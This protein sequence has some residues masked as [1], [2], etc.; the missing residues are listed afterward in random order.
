MNAKTET[1]VASGNQFHSKNTLELLAHL[2]EQTSDVLTAADINFKPLTWNKA[3][4]K[5][6]GLTSE[7]VIGSDVRNFLVINYSGT[8]RDEVRRIINTTGEWRGEANFVRPTDNKLITLLIAFKQLKEDGEV[9]GYL[10]C[11]TD[12]TERKKAEQRL[13]ESE[14]RFRNMADSSPAMIWLS[15]ESNHTIYTNQKW[16]EFTGQQI[17]NNKEGWRDFVHKDDLAKA[18][19]VFDEAFNQK[20]EVAIVYRLRRFDGTYRWVHDTSVPRFLSDG[21]FIGYIGSV[22]DIEDE[23]QKQEQLVYQATI[24]ENVSDIIFT[25]DLNNIIRTWNGPAEEHY[26]ICAKDAIAKRVR[27][28]LSFTFYD[29][30]QEEAYQHLLNKGI[31]KGEISFAKKNGDVLY[32]NHTVKYIYN[33]E[34][35]KIGFLAVGQDITKKKLAEEQMKE[36][37][38]FY[39]TLIADSLDGM[40]LTN[41][42]GKITFCSPS[43]KNVLG[44]Q[45]DEIVGKNAFEFVHP[46]DATYA[47]TS[48]QREVKEN[49]EVKYITVRLLKNT[50][51]WIWCM[52][53][54][55]NLLE[56]SYINSIVIYFHDDSLRKRAQDALK[57][58]E[59]RFRSLVRDLQIGVFLSDGNGNIIMC[60]Q[61]LSSMLSIPEEWVVGKNVYDIISDDVINEKNE[62]IPLEERPLTQ[63]LHLKKTIKDVVIGLLHPITKE[64]CWILVNSNP[65]LDEE[66]NLKHVVCS[67]MN[68]TERKKLEQKLITDQISHQRQLTQ[69]TI[70]GQEKERTE[71]GKELHDN[72]GQQLTSI[73]LF[74]DLAKNTADEAT[75]EMVIMAIKGVSDAINEVRAMSRS[76]VPHTL[77]DLGLIESINE[78]I[79]SFSRTQLLTIEMND[80]EFDEGVLP[81]NQKLTLFRIVQEQLNNI[82]KHAQADHVQIKLFSTSDGILLEIKDDGNGFDIEKVRKGLGFINIKNRAELFNGNAEIFSKPGKGCLL[83]VFFP[84]PSLT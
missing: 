33:P 40:I 68:L 20:K 76:L 46:D 37:E 3:A 57:E 72:V 47:F 32:F 39:R 61:A 66:G 73:K 22:I 81:E 71:I 11:G 19:N 52:V 7:Q 58:S 15:D 69:A 65:I 53:R 24:L 9:T 27:D 31:W 14:Q 34:G 38:L 5:I 49:P 29:T 50:G 82:I 44:F 17:V 16:V 67:V 4:E 35:E 63:T 59:N 6:Y 79:D 70:D 54:G 10:I 78:L 25:T 23:K 42:D 13:K 43:V 83:K 21:R 74:L 12:I 41:A 51:E 75:L 80:V 30:T 84:P 26:G 62:F 8:T 2:V 56:N 60:N 1:A 18:K 28:V 77:K 48:F 45:V 55:H 36:S 64:R